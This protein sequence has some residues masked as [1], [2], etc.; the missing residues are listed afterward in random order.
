MAICGL[1]SPLDDYGLSVHCPLDNGRHTLEPKCSI[2]ALVV[3]P[4][5]ILFD[6]L[7]RLDLKTLTDFRR[8]NQRAMEVV[9]ST[10]EYKAIVT[11]VPNFLRVIL[12]LKTGPWISCQ[13]LNDKFLDS[14]CEYCNDIGGYLYLLTCRRVCF[15]CY[16]KK[17]YQF[18]PVD[19]YEAER[20]YGIWVDED[21][22]IA[23]SIYDGNRILVPHMTVPKRFGLEYQEPSDLCYLDHNSL[24]SV[25]S[26]PYVYFIYPEDSDSDEPVRMYNWYSENMIRRFKSSEVHLFKDLQDH[27]CS[28]QQVLATIRA[29]WWN[30]TE[31]C[32]EWG[33]HCRACQDPISYPKYG[34]RLFTAA[35]FGEHIKELGGIRKC[36][37]QPSPH[38]YSH[39]GTCE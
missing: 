25:A 11:N 26:D 12:G 4:L 6:V 9:D 24:L 37:G 21:T 10:P 23:E 31:K 18:C 7:V 15:I 16:Q 38:D 1:C 17:K 36:H 3:L 2:G 34:M 13:L 8:V 22:M 27:E 33:F 14:R 20:H 19:W 35:T 39:E 28:A 30:Q 5:E 32:V 29:P